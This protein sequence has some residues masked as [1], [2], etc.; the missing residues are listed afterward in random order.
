MLPAC[1]LAEGV[2]VRPVA[3]PRSRAALIA[4]NCKA[5]SL[6]PTVDPEAVVK[7]P[8]GNMPVTGPGSTS[9]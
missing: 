5:P 9:I 6:G 7:A 3:E 1:H 4:E 8:S 2:W